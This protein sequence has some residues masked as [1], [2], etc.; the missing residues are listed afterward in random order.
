MAVSSGNLNDLYSD[1]VADLIP[2]YDNAVLLPNPS[3]IVNSY[4]LEGG[5]GNTVKIPVTNAYGTSNVSIADN[6]S[7]LT[8][9]G[10]N[11]D[12]NPSNVSLSVVKRGTGSRVSTESME[13]GGMST[14]AGATTMRLAKSIANSTDIAGFRTMLSGSETE[15]TDIANINVTNDGYAAATLG[16]GCE[17][18]VVFSP[19]AGAYAV[20]RQPEVKMFEDIDTD[21]VE[22]VATL[23]NGFAQ[24]Q[25]SFIRAIA[26]EGLSAN[27]ATS[28]SLDQFATSIANLRAVNA[29]T[30]AGGFYIACI[31][32]GQELHLSK[33]LNGVGGI[34]SG[35]IGSV[36]QLAANDALLQGLVSVAVG[37]RFVRS[38]HLPTGLASA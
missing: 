30:D 26:T 12:F 11:S 9:A 29:P 14:V 37:A 33:E 19:E 35:S 23:R 16:S 24:V 15:L 27:A 32:P 8:L 2:Y 34:A 22:F 17:L 28:A 38:N 6:A 18:A 10:T 25:T 21:S 7:I 20:K 36:A 31:T 13:D 4:N 5:V 1:I 3:L